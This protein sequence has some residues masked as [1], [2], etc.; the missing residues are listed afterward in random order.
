MAENNK[1]TYFRQTP[2]ETIPNNVKDPNICITLPEDMRKHLDQWLLRYPPDQRRSG[3]YEALR[4]VQEMNG[5]SLTVPL[6]D[7]VADYLGMSKI[8][9]YEVAAFYTMY[10]LDPVGR[11]IV[12]VCTNISCRLNGAEKLLKHL[13]H[14]LQIK[15]N[16]TTPDGQFTL[17]EVECLGACVSAPVCMIGKDYHLNLTPEK[18]DEILARLNTK[19]SIEFDNF[20]K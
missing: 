8:G 9:V 15:L 20:E 6:M 19:D 10:H 3:V 18:L 13:E 12:D 5:G 2:E 16:E 17:K 11:H 7:A 1:A 14:R 4:C